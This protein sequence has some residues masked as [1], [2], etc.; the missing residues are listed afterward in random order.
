MEKTDSNLTIEEIQKLWKENRKVSWS[1]IQTIYV[2][3][4]AVLGGAFIA[5]L[6]SKT[7]MLALVPLFIGLYLM[8]VMFFAMYRDMQHSDYFRERAIDAG[9]YGNFKKH[10]LCWKTGYV[11]ITIPVVLGLVNLVLGIGLFCLR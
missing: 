8:F 4:A 10:L 9:M 11:V 3:E 7:C 1:R 6:D 5:F 2:F